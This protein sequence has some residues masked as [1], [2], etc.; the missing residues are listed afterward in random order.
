MSENVWVLLRLES[1]SKPVF[2][3][4]EVSFSDLKLAENKCTLETFCLM[5]QEIN[6]TNVEKG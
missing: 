3:F 6:S 5:T 2:L 1:L 4:V